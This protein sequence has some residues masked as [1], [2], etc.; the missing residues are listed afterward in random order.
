MPSTRTRRK[1]IPKKKTTLDESIEAVLLSGNADRD[2][3]GWRLKT[4][5][6]FDDGELLR[7]TWKEHGGYLK[8]RWKLENQDEPWIEKILKHFDQRQQTGDI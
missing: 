1:R 3:D 4:S 2:S 8:A 6:F 5:R 7:E